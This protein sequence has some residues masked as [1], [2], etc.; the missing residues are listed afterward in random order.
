M[1]RYSPRYRQVYPDPKGTYRY[2]EGMEE[3]WVG[4]WVKY[5]DVKKIIEFFKFFKEEITEL[6]KELEQCVVEIK[7]LIKEIDDLHNQI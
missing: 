2:I 7:D 4:E 6:D 5:E 3:S 1:K